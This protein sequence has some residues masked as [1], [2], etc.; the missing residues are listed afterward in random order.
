V[1]FDRSQFRDLIARRLVERGLH[2]EAA[3]NLLM[4]TAAQESRL[5]TYLRQMRGPAIG[6]FQMEPG[7]FNWLRDRYAAQ[8]PEIACRECEEMEWDIDL[9]ILFARLRY[10]VVPIPL[11]AADDVLGLGGY[12]KAHYNTPAGKA[13]VAD[14]VRNYQR[15]AAPSA[16]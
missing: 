3:V 5:G 2:S 15:Y 16:G 10:L 4:G 9:A 7:T 6:V 8:Y 13:T 12:Y 14:F 1:S 11:P